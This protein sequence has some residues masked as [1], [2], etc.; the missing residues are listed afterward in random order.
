M[1]VPV[2]EGFTSATGSGSAS[3]SK[4]SGVTAGDLLLLLVGSDN[5]TGGQD[6]AVPSGWT[7][8]DEVGDT[9]TDCHVA[10]MWRV[11]DGTEGSSQTVTD[12]SGSTDIGVF[13][14][15]ISGT[16]QSSSLIFDTVDSYVSTADTTNFTQGNVPSTYDNHDGLLLGVVSYDGGDGVIG[17]DSD[18]AWSDSDASN[19]DSNGLLLAS[20]RLLEIGTSAGV[21]VGWSYKEYVAGSSNLAG[22]HWEASLSDGWAHIQVKINAAGIQA[23]GNVTLAGS[24]VSG[25]TVVAVTGES[26]SMTG[27]VVKA[28]T[29]TD[30]NGDYSIAEYI[31]DIPSPNTVVYCIHKSGSDTYTAPLHVIWS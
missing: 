25:A 17:T 3:P 9:V 22:N 29:S 19:T 5:I 23:S 13:Y 24:P 31:S 2:I 4:P 30:V 28:V 27:A 8:L 16:A 12:T 26:A 14:L 7:L 20:G 15:R 11:A 6:F 21:S 1:A 18:A 10:I